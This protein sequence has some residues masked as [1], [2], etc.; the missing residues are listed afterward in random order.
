MPQPKMSVGQG[1]ASS[2]SNLQL[3]RRLFFDEGRD[4][5]TLVSDFIVRSWRRCCDVAPEDAD[6]F[7]PLAQQELLLLRDAHGRLRHH[8]L[9]ELEALAEAMAPAH[10]IV[11]LADTQGFI[12]DAAGSDVF[13]SKAQRVALM[14]GVDWSESSR[15]TNAIGTALSEANPVAVLGAEHYL[16][17]NALLGCT[18]VPLMAPDGKIM[19][20]LDLSGDP[21]LI[22]EQTT[23]LVRMTA[24]MIEHRICLDPQNAQVDILRFANEAALLGTHREGLLWV[25]AGRIVGANRN[26]QRLLGMSLARLQCLCLSDVFSEMPGLTR[27]KG[28]L[29]LRHGLA[30]PDHST[31]SWLS[32]WVRRDKT[33]HVADASLVQAAVRAKD[34]N[35][36]APM[37]QSIISDP[38]R[39]AQLANANR[40]IDCDIPV[41]IL[42]ESGVGKEVFAKQLHQLSRRRQGPFV[43]INCAAIPEGLIEAELFG[44]EDG[45]FTGARRKGQLG[46]IREAHGGVLF[47]DEIGDMPLM[48]QA[49]LL[50]VLQDRELQPLGGGRKYAVDFALVCATHRNLAEMVADGRFRTDL[51]FRLQHFTV[52]LPA[53]RHQV[54]GQARIEK[55]LEHLLAPK[56]LDLSPQAREALLCYEWPG[57]W[58]QLVA[59]GQT[60]AAL[61]EPGCRIEFADLP[62][63]IRASWPKHASVAGPGPSG[64]NRQVQADLRALTDFAIQNAID[65]CAGNISHAARLLG[66]HRSTLYRH[67]LQRKCAEPKATVGHS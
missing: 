6:S 5:G 41:L 67:M 65:S 39:D 57:N 22:H 49:R 61:S 19:G 11:I 18:A 9:P 27:E 30:V 25:N 12:L 35:R 20:V 62:C 1:S 66:I 43:A 14:P 38:R 52:E 42:G 40:V 36:Q 34:E 51:Y 15:G 50:R 60:L 2:R 13:I 3:A 8:A 33:Q 58:R 47:L 54:D 21:S 4:P 45:A 53:L 24:Q 56:E 7:E 28:V 44:Y 26:A 59:V 63:D 37:A 29:S 23:A 46:R 55:L 31:S 16:A 17:M 48:L 32:A 10:G 64:V